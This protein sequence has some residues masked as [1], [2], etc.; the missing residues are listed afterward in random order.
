M[1]RLIGTS[2]AV[3]FLAVILLFSLSSLSR[4]A[5]PG[6]GISDLW[7]GYKGVKWGATKDE[8]KR[9]R[10][11]VPFVSGW[12]KTE[13][14]T[15]LGYK[16]DTIDYHFN[17]D[18]KFYRMSVMILGKVACDRLIEKYVD[19]YGYPPDKR[20]HWFVGS[21]GVSMLS[22]GPAG[23]DWSL[24]M[25]FSKDYDPDEAPGWKEATEWM[26]KGEKYK[27]NKEFDKALECYN[28]AIK[29]KRN[30]RFAYEGRA[31]VYEETKK[32]S[33][34]I[35]EYTNVINVD[36]EYPRSYI[37]RGSA[38]TKIK[39]YDKALADFTAAL[40][41]NPEESE[42][43]DAYINMGEMYSELK[44]YP[45]SVELY[46]KAMAVDPDDYDGSEYKSRA[47][48]YLA[49][50]KQKEAIDD[51]SKVIELDPNN[52]ANYNT[53]AWT[54]YEMGQYEKGLDDANKALK[55]KP[56]AAYILD[57]RSNIYRGLGKYSK[58]MDDINKAI[59]LKPDQA[60]YYYTRGL[61]YEAMG[62]K[63]KALA[64]LKKSCDMGEKDACDEYAKLNK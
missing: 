62:E 41:R 51:F 63:D 19:S 12:G 36:T 4:A 47:Y 61:N 52:A 9:L 53:R 38:Y 39:N 5:E 49:Q 2:I 20:A 14:E 26:E 32:Y 45:K 28:E 25:V 57:T 37:N 54:Y 35:L 6:D 42:K 21:T 22:G 34:A 23:H 50:G 3:V 24:I 18:K 15:F 11:D 56:D 29:I 48:A 40:A 1:K 8:F 44:D 59:E 7:Y 60:F 55:I 64:D 46:T 13:G 17:D 30:F 27:D 16:T 43:K 33:E 58:A 31:K 10:P